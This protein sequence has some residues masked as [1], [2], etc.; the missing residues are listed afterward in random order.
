MAGIRR[1]EVGALVPGNMRGLRRGFITPG[2]VADVALAAE[3]LRAT[4][5]DVSRNL[6]RVVAGTGLV[7]LVVE[8]AVLTASL[9]GR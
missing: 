1:I 4:P 7:L 5:H 8:V 6:W 2:A 9:F 3:P